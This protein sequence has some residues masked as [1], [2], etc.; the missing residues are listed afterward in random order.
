MSQC[1]Y[2]PGNI[3]KSRKHLQVHQCL[4]V[5]CHPFLQNYPKHAWDELHAWSSFV[6]E[7]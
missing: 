1:T 4:V 7:W 5:P 6:L 2:L 3:E